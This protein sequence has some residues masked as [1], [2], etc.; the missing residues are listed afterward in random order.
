MQSSHV[1]NNSPILPL[2]RPNIHNLNNNKI[3][4]YKINFGYSK[5]TADFK[6]S[7]RA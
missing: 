3:V 5:Y 4:K 6:T 2:P 7:N 1:Y